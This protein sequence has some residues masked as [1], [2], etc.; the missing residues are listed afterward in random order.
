MMNQ[1]DLS[2]IRRRLNPDKR[3]P[4]MIRGCYVSFDGQVIST[5]AHP[6]Y[7]MPQE[8]TEKY[9]AIFKRTLSGTAGQN[10]MEVEFTAAQA[11]EGE[12]HRLLRTLRDTQL[13]DERTVEEFYN[14]AIS[15]VLEEKEKLA[16]SVSE[17]QN[18]S[19]YL[20]LLMHDGYDVP[21]KD[22]NDEIDRERSADLFSYIICSICPVK[23][24]KPALSYF[25]AE[26][27][28]H[29]KASDWVV[30]A[31]EAG[32]MFPCFEERA[33]N[34]YAAQYY[35]RSAE[36]M[37]DGFIQA[38][39]GTEP[40]MPA[41]AQKETFQA[42]LQDTLKEECSLDVMAAVHDTVSTMIEERKADKKAEPLRLTRQDVKDVLES[43]GVSQEKTE[44]F[45]QQYT[46]TFGKF[47]E[48]PAVNVVTPKQFKVETPSVSIRV[49]PEHSDLIETRVIDGKRYI[50]VLA[51]GDVEVN[52][53]Q[54]SI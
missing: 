19:N 22:N 35:T 4:T 28:F 41:Q 2:E 43:C 24:T 53:V 47:A 46:E 25:A 3:N 52:G 18:A 21:Y 20:I 39:F 17:A 50:L 40:F 16:Q 27:E 44:A 45:D 38:V 31:P 7:G 6:V 32:F 49:D 42:I 15:F 23:Q 37:H 34:L 12:E 29:N 13:K 54:V 5:F 36:N 26:S 51:D 33:T 8:E 11:M 48:L 10:L 9:M 14:R 1:R 30:G